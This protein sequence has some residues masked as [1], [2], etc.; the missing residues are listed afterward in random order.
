MKKASLDAGRNRQ[1]QDEFS[2]ALRPPGHRQQLSAQQPRQ[3][4]GKGEAQAGALAL[5]PRLGDVD[6]EDPFDIIL[7]DPGALRL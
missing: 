5:F 6:I 1:K 4:P 3:P 2:P 7:R